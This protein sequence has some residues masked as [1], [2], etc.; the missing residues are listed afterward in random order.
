MRDRTDFLSISLRAPNDRKSFYFVL[1]HTHHTHYRTA[2]RDIALPDLINRNW[3]AHEW[4]LLSLEARPWHRYVKRDVPSWKRSRLS[5]IFQLFSAT[6]LTSLS[7]H[8]PT[9]PF[10]PP[11][12]RFLLSLSPPAL[13]LPPA[14]LLLPHLLPP[15]SSRVLFSFVFNAQANVI[16]TCRRPCTA[17]RAHTNASLCTR[18]IRLIL[19]R[20]VIRRF[21]A[22]RVFAG[23]LRRSGGTPPRDTG[24]ARELVKHEHIKCSL[25]LAFMPSELS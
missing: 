23:E 14:P 18:V 24:S 20:D 22:G 19:S 7:S 3:W 1:I 25:L 11:L 16:V 17:K 13:L 4:F 5:R 12:S 8:L 10:F 15:T 21:T 6:R 2:Y 9:S